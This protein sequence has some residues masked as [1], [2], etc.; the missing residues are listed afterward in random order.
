[1][2]GVF[3]SFYARFDEIALH[4]PPTC[5]K[6]RDVALFPRRVLFGIFIIYYYLL[7]AILIGIKSIGQL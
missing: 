1:M 3:E 5:L 6:R 4:S 2:Q 7:K